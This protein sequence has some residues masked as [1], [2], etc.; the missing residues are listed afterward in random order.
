MDPT[1]DLVRAVGSEKVATNV[2]TRYILG[3]VLFHLLAQGFL[4]CVL[5][6]NAGHVGR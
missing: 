3:L 4:H 5:S 6:D 1:E 2:W